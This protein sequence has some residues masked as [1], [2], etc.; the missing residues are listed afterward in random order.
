[1]K[2]EIWAEVTCPW[3]GLGSH[4]LDRAVERFEH[5]DEVEVVH[6]SFPLSSSFPV[7]ADDGSAAS[8]A[9]G[10]P[11]QGARRGPPPGLCPDRPA[12]RLIHPSTPRKA[13]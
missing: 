6:H 12:G 9:R 7:R 8:D 4:R 11:D 10:I 13:F 1:M 5:G 3:C 2:I